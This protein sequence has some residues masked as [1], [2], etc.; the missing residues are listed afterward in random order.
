MS[1]IKTLPKELELKVMVNGEELTVVGKPIKAES[2]KSLVKTTHDLDFLNATSLSMEFRGSLADHNFYQ[3]SVTTKYGSKLTVSFTDSKSKVVFKNDPA[4]GDKEVH[5]VLIGRN[6]LTCQ[7]IMGYAVLESSQVEA[8][9]YIDKCFFHKSRVEGCRFQ[10]SK[11]VESVVSV[12]DESSIRKCEFQ[13]TTLDCDGYAL[14]AKSLFW[15]SEISCSGYANIIEFD[16]IGSAL[17]ANSLMV[18]MTTKSRTIRDLCITV[19]GELT[20]FHPICYLTSLGEWINPFSI[21]MVMGRYERKNGYW[22]KLAGDPDGIKFFTE[23]DIEGRGI[24]NYLYEALSPALEQP[25]EIVE[26]IIDQHQSTIR[27]RIDLI[28]LVSSSN[29]LLS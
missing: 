10:D 25:D 14:I 13:E 24:E 8:S 4:M 26:S 9:Y 1:N 18:N 28:N 3:G 23:Q 29:R 17:T 21:Q 6:Q 11:F 15:R 27:N 7:G 19:P 22:V 5:L 2:L 20:L 12:A 16:L